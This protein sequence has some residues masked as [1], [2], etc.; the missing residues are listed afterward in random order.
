MKQRSFAETGYERRPK[1]TKRQ[2]FLTEMDAVIPWARLMALVDP[3]QPKMTARGG[4][5]SYGAETMLRIHFMQQWFAL[6]DPGMEEALHDIPAMRAFA[7]L[8]AGDD[9]IPDESSILRFRHRLEKHGLAE[10][11]LAEVNALLTERGLLLKQGTLV[12]ATLVAAPSSTKNQTGERD[13][14][15]HQTKKGNN[16][17]FGMKA[18]IG[19][20]AESGLTHTVVTTAANVNDVTQA[21]ALL[22]GDEADVFGDAGYQGVEK[23]EEN[24]GK[25]VTWHVAMKPGKRRALPDTPLGELLEQ[26]ERAKSSLRAKV[27]HPF[28]V[29]KRQFGFLK[30]RYRGLRKNTAQIVT[31]FAL[32]NLFQARHRLLAQTGA[33]R[34]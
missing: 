33:V 11:M 4:Q 19:V 10:R 6:S 22:H 3:V 12:D 34:P 18:H 7:Q 5:V 1:A 25:A 24:A 13:P 26:I 17:H 28:R 9:L 21:H 15:M 2:R 29:I 14:E 32:A 27:E 23:R 16:W 30:T 8:D 20:D 31:L